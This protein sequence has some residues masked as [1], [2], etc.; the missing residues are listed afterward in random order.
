MGGDIQAEDDNYIAATFSS[1]IF[2]FV[3]DLEIR[4]DLTDK[5]I[6]IRSA[7]RVGHGDAGVNEKRADFLKKLISEKFAEGR[8]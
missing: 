7:S 3:D 1:A 8:S 4:V 5:M 2:G 6:H